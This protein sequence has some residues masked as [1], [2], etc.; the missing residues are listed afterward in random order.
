MASFTVKPSKNPELKQIPSF[1][2]NDSV[3][4]NSSAVFAGLITGTMDKLKVDA[5]A[6]SLSSCA[7]TAMITPVP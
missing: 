7:G 2:L 4:G 1:A 3:R 5:N 6:K